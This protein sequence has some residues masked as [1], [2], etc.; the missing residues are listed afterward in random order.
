M[1]HGQGRLSNGALLNKSLEIREILKLMRNDKNKYIEENEVTYL[2]PTHP[3]TQNVK[4][5]SDR[6]M[7]SQ[8]QTG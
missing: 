1:Q 4:C 8:T 6:R 2:F 5:L 7:S 3:T